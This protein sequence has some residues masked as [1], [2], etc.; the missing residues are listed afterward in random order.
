[1]AIKLDSG[2]LQ[3][4]ANPRE[5]KPAYN[6]Q[7]MLAMVDSIMEPWR[8][9]GGV[10]D[11]EKFDALQA[12]RL[13]Q[14]EDRNRGL[15]LEAERL[16]VSQQKADQSGKH[17]AGMLS[18]SQGRLAI[19]QD[20]EARLKGAQEFKE[21]Y[22]TEKLELEKEWKKR[23]L[24]INSSQIDPF[25]KKERIERL[26]LD[27]TTR[28]GNLKIASDRADATIANIEAQTQLRL[29][30]FD[31]NNEEARRERVRWSREESR[32]VGRVM[33]LAFDHHRTG[34]Q[35]GAKAA[36]G[37][38]MGG[39]PEDR[40]TH[41]EFIRD[42][43][44]H[45]HINDRFV[46]WFDDGERGKDGKPVL[47]PGS[48]SYAMG[49]QREGRPEDTRR[50]TANEQSLNHLYLEQEKQGNREITARYAAELKVWVEAQT[51][52]ISLSDDE[53]GSVFYLAS[54]LPGW[55]ATFGKSPLDEQHRVA[56]LVGLAAK[57][58]QANSG[59]KYNFFQ[60]ARI[61]GE[62][63]IDG[64]RRET[65]ENSFFDLFNRTGTDPS[66][67]APPVSDNRQPPLPESQQGSGI[68]PS[69]WKDGGMQ[70][71]QEFMQPSAAGSRDPRRRGVPT[72]Q[73]WTSYVDNNYDTFFSNKIRGRVPSEELKL[74]HR[75]LFPTNVEF[76]QF[77][78][79]KYGNKISNAEIIRLVELWG[80]PSIEPQ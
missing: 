5:I 79:R 73:G 50:L 19:G 74:R 9:S 71:K 33:R 72:E 16:K 60:A 46:Y 30:E 17:M 15:E 68:V 3:A 36:L 53:R 34:N 77:L 52:G 47:K 1:M 20:A 26:K 22:L 35:A 67:T 43:L 65:D 59:G 64:S 18:Y 4:L 31:N 49:M 6:T 28:L 62:R 25:M 51:S 75:N 69:E 12:E 14:D 63:L 55:Q 44:P 48:F 21:K 24:D 45:S 39:V 37:L 29:Q 61:F 2:V 13:R 23:R 58:L 7:D 76:A 42:P 27:F 80:Y 8:N 32:D 38:V 40:I 54:R 70:T 66:A 56:R 57:H 11:R 78:D 41:V 10:S